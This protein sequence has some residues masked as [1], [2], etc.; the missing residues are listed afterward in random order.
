MILKKSRDTPKFIIFL[1]GVH[2][3]IFSTSTLGNSIKYYF[4]VKKRERN[5]IKYLPS[6]LHVF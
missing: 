2:K 6:I 4:K 3:F 5:K 1:I